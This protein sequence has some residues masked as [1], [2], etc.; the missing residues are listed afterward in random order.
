MPVTDQHVAALRALILDDE[1]R[2]IPLTAQLTDDDMLA[3]ELLLRAALA[4]AAA[5]R[6]ASG[7]SH[8]DLIRYVARLRAGTADRAEDMDLDPLAAEA[9]LRRALGQP[10]PAVSDPRTR[11]R[12]TVA[13]LTVVVGDLALG[14]SRADALLVEARILANRWLAESANTAR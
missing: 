12:S 3:Y 8:G 2:F 13:L 11:L 4:L 5:R 1:R 6:F 7:F 14:E 9:T 10:A